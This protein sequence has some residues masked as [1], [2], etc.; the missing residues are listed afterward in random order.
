MSKPIPQDM[1]VGTYHKTT[2]CGDLVIKEYFSS[3]KV[4]VEFTLTG[5]TTSTTIQ[6]IRKGQVKDPLYPAI[7]GKGFL[8]IGKH[9]SRTK[10]KLK[11]AYNV[12]SKMLARCYD[13]SSKAYALYGAKGITVCKEWHNYQT[14]AEWYSQNVGEGLHVDKDILI[15]GNKVYGPHS[16]IAVTQTINSIKANAKQYTFKSPTGKKVNIYIT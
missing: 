5:Y 11:R 9:K 14:F 3:T 15:A 12:W 1:F 2:K 16:C 4:T 8:G 7:Y 13:P 10:G 6:N